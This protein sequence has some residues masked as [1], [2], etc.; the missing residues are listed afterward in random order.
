MGKAILELLD[1]DET[2]SLPNL[3]AKL[4]AMMEIEE[5]QDRRQACECAIAI[6]IDSMAD[7]YQSAQ[8][9]DYSLL[10]DSLPSESVMSSGGHKLH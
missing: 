10:Q 7:A 9:D 1:G 8:N 2:L 6:I 3:I 4:R 5:Q